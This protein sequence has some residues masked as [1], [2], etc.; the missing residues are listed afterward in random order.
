MTP[1]AQIQASIELLDD[2]FDTGRPADR[3][4]SQYFRARRYIGSKDKRSISKTIYQVLRQRL[5]FTYL[6]QKHELAVTPRFLVAVSLLKEE[7]NLESYFDGVAYNP[8]PFSSDAFKSFRALD[9]LELDSAPISVQLNIPEWLAPKLQKSLAENYVKEMKALNC[10]ANTDIR[11]NLLKVSMHDMVDLLESTTFECLQSKLSPWCIRFDQ[12]VALTSLDSFRQGYFEIQDEG[13]QLLALASEA[14]AG[15]KVVDFCAGAGGKSLAM[16]MMM[17]NK[18]VIYACDVHSKRL[19]QLSI[20]AKRAG[21]HNVRVHGL[22]SEHDKWI[23][24]H[25]KM[26]DLVLIDA[27][28]SGTGTWR[29]N[30]DS[31]WNLKPEHLNNLLVLQQSILQS[32]SRLVKPGGRLLYATCSLLAEENQLQIEQF[33][34]N[35]LDFKYRKIELPETTLSQLSANEYQQHQLML[36][37]AISGTDGFYVCALQREAKII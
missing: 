10:R 15:E 19:E 16:A 6:L 20:R 26:A 25:R 1:A 28:C 36:S 7:L 17:N 30:P 3:L 4:I 31:R 9:F 18:G 5:S 35:N 14:S 37:T 22:S 21:V 29:R 34:A 23:K 13:S 32:A 8:K 27:P 2:I 11:V 24:Q 12:R 33:L